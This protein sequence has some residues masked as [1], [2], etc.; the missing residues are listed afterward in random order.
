MLAPR[1][2]AYEGE[3]LAAPLALDVRTDPW[4]VA[5]PQGVF[6]ANSLHIMAWEAVVDFFAALGAL[7]A[8]DTRL[9]SAH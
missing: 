2:A 3:N 9:A 1:C 7:A 5:V 6:S 8:P 4:P